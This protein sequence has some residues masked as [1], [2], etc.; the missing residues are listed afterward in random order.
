MKE[1]LQDKAVVKTMQDLGAIP[2]FMDGPQ[3]KTYLKGD[4][5]LSVK[6]VTK[7]GLQTK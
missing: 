6:M 3:F 4:Y 1:A 2:A 7:L 5:E